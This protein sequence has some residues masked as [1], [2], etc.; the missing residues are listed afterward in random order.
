MNNFTKNIVNVSLLFVAT[1]AFASTQCVE[2]PQF[3]WFKTVRVTQKL[4]KSEKDE[5]MNNARRG[6]GADDATGDTRRGRGTD[7]GANHARRGADDAT[8]DTRRGRG[9]DDGAN[10]A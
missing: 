3:K 2:E 8:G 9:T 5:P 7:D 1:G 6:R 10:H 4:I